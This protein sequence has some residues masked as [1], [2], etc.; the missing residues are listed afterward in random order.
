MDVMRTTE[1]QLIFILML[2]SVFR[3]NKFLG[4][5]ENRKIIPFQL[6]VDWEIII[7][8]VRSG[9]DEGLEPCV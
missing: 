8:Y 7:F 1:S 4:N 9:T 2:V 6:S 3:I 5:W